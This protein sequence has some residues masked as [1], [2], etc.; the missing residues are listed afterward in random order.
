[1]S[2]QIY[3]VKTEF[4]DIADNESSYGFRIFD[5]YERLYSNNYGIEIK[6]MSDMELLKLVNEEFQSN[7]SEMLNHVRENGLGMNIDGTYYE[8]EEIKSF[9]E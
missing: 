3:I 9:L 5:D 4:I 7:D 1:M 8:W 6:S 2:N